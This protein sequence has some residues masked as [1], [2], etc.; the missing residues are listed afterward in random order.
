MRI[1]N[2]EIDLR[3]ETR[4]LGQLKSSADSTEYEERST[5][6]AVEQMAVQERTLDA[7]GDIEILP[8][9]GSRFSRELDKLRKAA[10][11]MDEASGLLAEMETGNETL[12]AETTAIE[13]LLASRRSSD[14]AGSGSGDGGGVGSLSSG[15][16]NRSPLDLLGPDSDST[17]NIT[18]R[19]VG[20]G[21]G[22]VRGGLPEE[23]RDGLDAFM[24]GMS[25]LKSRREK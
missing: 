12:A 21:V 13:A 14:R 20:S 22:A 18:P 1:I 7:I 23:Y 11:A 24:N 5:A 10:L 4:T 6:L 15:N 9:G 16:S 19:D 3:D 17:A 8:S 2:D 25:D